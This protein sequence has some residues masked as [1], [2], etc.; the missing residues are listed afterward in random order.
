MARGGLTEGGGGASSD[1]RENEGGLR[2]IEKQL[3]DSPC[4]FQSGMY[5]GIS[6]GGGGSGCFEGV[7]EG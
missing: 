7:S 6:L 2:G 1:G 5:N 3:E 4:F